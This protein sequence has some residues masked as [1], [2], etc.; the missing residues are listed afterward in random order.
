MCDMSRGFIE[1]L[2][3]EPIEMERV[4][5]A[6]DANMMALWDERS[7]SVVYEPVNNLSEC[8]DL[9]LPKIQKRPFDD[10]INR[11]RWKNRY[12][13]IMAN[14]RTVGE[15]L[16]ELNEKIRSGEPVHICGYVYLFDGE[17]VKV[18]TEYEFKHF[19]H[20]N[21]SDSDE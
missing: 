9:N 12:K 19:F 7:E 2:L 14:P 15:I 8:L 10:A 3:D 21:D 4:L 20:G 13:E 5:K 16:S 1:H 6:Y 11:E 18:F 17:G